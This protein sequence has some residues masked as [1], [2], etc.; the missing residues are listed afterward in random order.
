MLTIDFCGDKIQV[1]RKPFTR[2]RQL[3]PVVWI[4]D[5]TVIAVDFNINYLKGDKT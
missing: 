1:V 3:F 2:A 4:E 5:P